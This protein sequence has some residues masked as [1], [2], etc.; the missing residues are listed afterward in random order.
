MNDQINFASPFPQFS[1]TRPI[2]DEAAF[3]IHEY[4]KLVTSE[5]MLRYR[6]QVNRYVDADARLAET[7]D[8]PWVVEDDDLPF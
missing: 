3:E 2:S 7:S 5:F 8:V 1:K 6:V 4:L